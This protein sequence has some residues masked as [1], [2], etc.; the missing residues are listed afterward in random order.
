MFDTALNDQFPGGGAAYAGYVDGH[1]GNQPNYAYIVSAFPKAQHLSIALFASDNAD[2]L[3][4]EPGAS[5]P[6]DIPGWYARQV[7]RGI[8]RPVI[9][10]S[11]STMN[12]EILPLLSQAGIARARTRLWSAH[13]GAGEHICGPGS[14]GSLSV[15]ADGTQWTS[16]ARGLVLDQSLLASN[17]F[18]AAKVQ[19][20]VMEAE[21]QSGQLNNGHGA[22]TVI[23][24]PPGSA[25]QIAFGA[26]DTAQNTGVARLRVAFFDTAWHVH[27]D[28]VIGDNHGLGVVAFTNP[29]RTGIISVRRS[30]NG[31]TAVGYVV[32]LPGRRSAPRSRLSAAAYSSGRFTLTSESRPGSAAASSGPASSLA[33][34]ARLTAQTANRSAGRSRPAASSASAAV[35]SATR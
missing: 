23:A 35:A 30:D 18:T 3:D 2:V 14:C 16:N 21:L 22:F 1:V 27:P 15:N 26:D 20:T 6:S 25:H 9:Y 31:S 17:F 29:A 11:A 34:S 28:V 13:Y 8:Q 33:S 10:A 19:P 4:V 7:A 24:V 5:S 12:D 32:Y